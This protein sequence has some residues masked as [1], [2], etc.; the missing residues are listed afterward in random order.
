LKKKEK[1]LLYKYY[2]SEIA[3]LFCF[4]VVVLARDRMKHSVLKNQNIGN[5]SIHVI[6]LKK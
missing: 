4:V 6:V 1:I 5:F 3:F 2:L